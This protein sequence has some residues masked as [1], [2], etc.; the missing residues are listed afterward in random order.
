MTQYQGKN[1]SHVFGSEG[2]NYNKVVFSKGRPVLDAELNLL[3]EIS[4]QLARRSFS[5]TPSGWLSKRD[6]SFSTSSSMAD[7]FYTQD[8]ASPVPEVAVVN[9]WPIL[10]TNTGTDTNLVNKVDVSKFPLVKGSRADGVFLEVWRSIISNEFSGTTTPADA[11]VVTSL[12]AVYSLDANNG[13]AVGN[14]GVLLKTSNGGVSWLSQG[15]PTSCN[16]RAVTFIDANRGYI[17]GDSGSLFRTDNGGGTWAKVAV[18][19]VDS[20]KSISAVAPSLVIVCGENGTILKSIDGA[21]FRLVATG[22]VST[23]LLSV[24]LFDSN[25]GWACGSEGTLLKTLDGGDTW[26]RISITTQDSNGVRVS[27]TGRLNSIKFVNLNDGWAVGDTGLILRTTDGG[28][29]WGDTSSSIYS[30]A[31]GSYTKV[32]ENLYSLE[33]VKSFPLR[34]SFSLFDSSFFRSGTYVLTPTTMVL[35]YVRASDS[36][37]FTQTLVL[38]N[39]ATDQ[40]L[41]DAIN[42]VRSPENRRVYTATLGYSETSY[43][44]HATYGTVYTGATDIKFSLGD[45]A[46]IAGQRGTILSTTNSGAQWIQESSGT[47]FDL[48]GVSFNGESTGWSVGDQGGVV[49]Y[50]SS[51]SPLWKAQSTDLGASASKKVYYEGNQL[52]SVSK[53]LNMDSV[54][55]DVRVV[56]ADREQIQYRI[57]VVE[58][59][60]FGAYQ[61]AGLGAPYV[62]SQGP[63]TSVVSAG[64]YSYENMGSTNGDYGMWRAKCRSTVDGYSYAIPMFLVSR[65]NA[66]PFDPLNNINGSSITALSTVRPDGLLPGTIIAEDVVDIRKSILLSDTQSLLQRSFD[67]LLSNTIRTKFGRNQE[68]GTQIGSSVLIKDVYA[69]ANERSAL[70]GGGISSAA[71]GGITGFAGPQDGSGI[72]AATNG[73]LPAQ[74]DLTFPSQVNQIWEHSAKLYSA[75]YSGTGD[76]AIDGTSIPGGFTGQG[77]IAASFVLGAT[78]VYTGLEHPGLT[79][80]VAGRK[81]DF[82]KQGLSHVPQTPLSVRNADTVDSTQTVYYRSVRSDEGQKVIYEFSS[83]VSGKT[84]Y[85]TS[86]PVYLADAGTPTSSAVKVH[87]FLQPTVATTVLRVPKDMDGYTVYA[88]ESVKGANGTL[89][90]ISTVR[91]R[92]VPAGSSLVSTDN[93]IIYLEEAFAVPANGVVEVILA[94]NEVPQASSGLVDPTILGI[95]GTDRGETIYSFRNPNISVVDI[96]NK[97]VEGFYRSVLVPATMYQGSSVVSVEAPQGSVIVGLASYPT[98]SSATNYYCWYTTDDITKFQSGNPG[99]YLKTVPVDMTQP[100]PVYGFGTSSIILSLKSGDGGVPLNTQAQLVV[101]VYIKDA[102]LE[103]NSSTSTA[104]VYYRSV[105][106]QTVESL[107]TSLELEVLGVHGSMV[108]T[109]LGEGGG[110]PGAFYLNPTT[111]IPVNDST[112]ATESFY[113]NLYGMQYQGYTE[114]EGYS[115]LPL[116]SYRT[117][118]GSLT[119]SNPTSDSYGRFFYKNADKAM[120]FKGQPLVQ[121]TPRKLFVP[122]LV[123]VV[124]DVLSPVL[125]GEILLAVVTASRNTELENVI[126]LDSS[127]TGT[128]VALYRIPGMPLTRG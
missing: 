52:A 89:H 37:E 15:S 101:P 23:D 2:Y 103:N 98:V 97:A 45:R 96:R 56:T 48:L 93:H 126:K 100:T 9:G 73:T 69:T 35:K 7:S 64:S 95:S 3:Q 109:S 65:R 17:S 128:A 108:A 34:I 85:I 57:R 102:A 51:S 13:W 119:L 55:P 40:Q 19:A 110:I 115:T 125:R 31:Q 94:V 14:N 43:E 105:V 92:E 47:G 90:R 10:V 11:S 117:V 41:V 80:V 58:G 67:D 61:E 33:V 104:E 127:T 82:S 20:L 116:Q 118:G 78:G 24:C 60:D 111:V 27:V 121:G 75:T 76:P 88:V 22:K 5:G 113:Y 84:N 112:V 99:T 39:Y 36:V 21:T 66:A 54:H 122:I 124:S 6:P 68:N 70:A 28:S 114:L 44:S 4:E 106:P 46:W 72:I 77:T 59:V 29:T 91:D 107:G 42:G 87:Y 12:N 16:L 8:P 81:V 83:D 62:Y 71:T 32:L 50:D 38:A 123:K 79:Y 86:T 74:S 53:N 63:N 1:V 25:V 18:P 26:N 49:R 30:P 120:V